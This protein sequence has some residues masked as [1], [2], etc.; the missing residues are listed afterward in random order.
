MGQR[1]RLL[2]R[3]ILVISFTIVALGNLDWCWTGQP[4]RLQARASLCE[5]CKLPSEEAPFANLEDIAPG[6]V[7]N[8]AVPS[9]VSELAATCILAAAVLAGLVLSP[10]AARAEQA[11]V[12]SKIMVGGAS[13]QDRGSRKTITRGMNLDNANYSNQDLSGVSFQ[14]SLVR[15]GKFVNA[16]LE[17]ASF[18]DADLQGADFTGAKMSQVNLELARLTDT[19]FDNA[20]AT[21]MYVN[22]TTKMEPKSINGTDFTDTPFRK[23]QL[24]YLCKIAAGTNPVTKVNTRESLGCP[25]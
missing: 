20:I 6:L 24:N 13:T 19:V 5:G 18:F 8:S 21:E 4:A 16:K 25:E 3:S 14:Q 10:T 22:G 2:A 23:D 9:K 12:T 17:G 15:S 7:L 1:Q 11:L